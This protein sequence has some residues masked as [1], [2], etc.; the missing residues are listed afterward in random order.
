MAQPTF[1]S[2]IMAMGDDGM[3]LP[4]DEETGMEKLWRK[5]KQDPMVPIGAYC[6]CM[7]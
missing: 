3:P 4:L 1:S 2:A 6:E 5:L 7:R